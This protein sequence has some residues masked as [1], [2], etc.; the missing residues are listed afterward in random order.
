[1]AELDRMSTTT[2]L[3]VAALVPARRA[4]SVTPVEALAAR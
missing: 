2:L 4:T 3:V 1:V